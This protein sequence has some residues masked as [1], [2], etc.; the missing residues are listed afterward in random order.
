LSPH[1]KATAPATVPP[2]LAQRLPRVAGRVVLREALL[3]VF[4]QVIVGYFAEINMRSGFPVVDILR[5][6]FF[7]DPAAIA[8]LAVQYG[9]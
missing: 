5:G 2:R 4:Q 1:G 8:V 3:G 9:E 7:L 6:V